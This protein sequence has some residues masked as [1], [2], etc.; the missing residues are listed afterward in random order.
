MRR[1]YVG[2]SVLFCIV[3]ILGPIA[4]TGQS[5]IFAYPIGGQ[6]EEQV[7]RD[8]FECHQWAVGQTGFNPATAPPL[9]ARA[10]I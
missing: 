7:S 3:G 6:S 2:C 8:K 10:T 5:Q 9:P 1:L 4:A